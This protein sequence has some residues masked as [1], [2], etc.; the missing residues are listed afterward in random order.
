M[1]INNRRDKTV[2]AHQKTTA[3]PNPKS[4]KLELPWLLTSDLPSNGPLTFIV[5]DEISHIILS[6]SNPRINR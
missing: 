3:Q 5:D 6:D 4:N 2:S 1:Y